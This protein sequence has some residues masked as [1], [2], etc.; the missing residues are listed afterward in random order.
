MNARPG[1]V[2][3]TQAQPEPQPQACP[4]CG[5]KHTL[6]FLVRD[7]VPVHQNLVL[8]NQDSAVAVSLGD[9]TLH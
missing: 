1:D 9:R 7:N 6:P 5:G 8:P 3:A 2:H 4:V